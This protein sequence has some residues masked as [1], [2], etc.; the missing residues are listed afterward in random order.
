MFT[1]R[2]CYDFDP[3]IDELFDTT[4]NILHLLNPEVIDKEGNASVSEEL[5]KL[6][7]VFILP[8]VLLHEKDKSNIVSVLKEIEKQQEKVE[9]QI[10]S[11][12]RTKRNT[13]N[14]MWKQRQDILRTENFASARY[15]SSLDENFLKILLKH[16]EKD[17]VKL[18]DI[19]LKTD[20]KIGAL[21]YSTREKEVEKLTK[22]RQEQGE[23]FKVLEV[24]TTAREEIKNVVFREH[25]RS[26]FRKTRTHLVDFHLIYLEVNRRLEKICEELWTLVGHKIKLSGVREAANLTL[27]EISTDGQSYGYNR[28]K[29]TFEKEIDLFDSTKKPEAWTTL[30]EK[31]KSCLNGKH[32]GFKRDYVKFCGMI[33]AKCEQIKNE[34][35]LFGSSPVEIPNTPPLS[36]DTAALVDRI[37]GE[38]VK[39]RTRYSLGVVEEKDGGEVQIRRQSCSPRWTVAPVS[40][41]ALESICKEVLDHITEMSRRLAIELKGNTRDNIDRNFVH[42][43]YVCYEQYVSEELVTILSDVFEMHY[44]QK[45]WNLSQWIERHSS[46]LDMEEIM[47]NLIP[48]S[49]TS[50]EEN[51]ADE[52]SDTE[53]KIPI[54]SVRT[55]PSPAL[56]CTLDSRDLK[57]MPWK[58]LYERMNKQHQ[59][60]DDDF[61]GALD[62]EPCMLE[63]GGSSDLV[64]NNHL[65]DSTEPSTEVGH[66]SKNADGHSDCRDS[67]GASSVGGTLPEEKPP[68]YSE[69]VTGI[70]PDKMIHSSGDCPPPYSTLPPLKRQF[71]DTFEKFF[72]YIEEEDK[73][74]SLFSKLGILTQ[75]IKYIGAQIS[76]NR[77]N[78]A[79]GAPCA[80]DLLDVVVVL[81]C[82]LNSDWL[83]KLYAHLNLMIFLLPEFMHGNAHEYSLVNFS[84]AYQYLFEKELM[85]KNSRLTASI[86]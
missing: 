73:A 2:Q 26:M 41:T 5:I 36:P 32:S 42:K 51:S 67:G 8:E 28:K 31:V 52:Y 49:L 50:S 64:F 74:C 68:P 13:E 33:R 59:S 77:G 85:D 53:V 60:V 22:A 47:Q 58:E 61:V 30:Q 70:K 48:S 44:K 56:S 11:K 34:S 6:L 71:Y 86:M 4:R 35:K 62:I 25:S 1:D 63:A 16:I 20:Q 76:K 79:D 12:E 46:K 45:C 66:D 55:E 9:D 75:S 84:M 21:R 17:L 38:S 40:Q 83:L 10:Q 24:F 57:N 69:A 15:V 39:R 14:S 27:K 80:D 81:L 29:G 54:D 18:N 19:F 23:V 7:H 78:T 65:E 43:V 3:T 72:E 82:K 37:G